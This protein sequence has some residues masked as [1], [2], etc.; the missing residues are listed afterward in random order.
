MTDDAIAKSS[1]ATAVAGGGAVLIMLA[2]AQFLMALDTSVMNVCIAQVA[3][4]VHTTVTGIQSAI[5]L[6][7]L[8]MASLMITGGKLGALIG[9]KRIFLIG[10]IVY[11][12]GSMTTA[13]S[14]SLP[15]LLI[16]WSLLEGIGAA[17]IMPA[18][19]ALVAGN[20]PAERRPA[21]YGLIAAA[22]AMAVAVGPLVG[23]AAATYATWRLVFAGEVLIVVLIMILARRAQDAPPDRRPKLDPVGVLLS[24]VGLAS[25]V[26]GVLKSSSWG[27][28]QP[29]PDQPALFGIS[30]VFWLMA[31]GGMVLYCFALWERRVEKRG[32]EPLVTPGIL[33]NARL[34]SGLNSFF[35][36]YMIQAGTFFIIP[37][38]L[39]V[40]L[41]LSPIATGVR[42]LPLSIGLLLTAVLV[43]RLLPHGSPRRIVRVGL[44][45]MLVSLLTLLAAMDVTA[46]AGVVLV[47]LFLMGLGVGALASQLGAVTVSAVPDS[48]SAEVGGLQNTFMFLGSSLGTALVGAVLIG[49]L[50]TSAITGISG[51]TGVPESVKQEATVKMQ[52]GVPFVSDAQLTAAMNEAGVP[53]ATADQVLAVNEQARVEGLQSALALLSALTILA[54][55]ATS[56][57]PKLLTAPPGEGDEARAQ[58]PA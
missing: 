32:G 35:F 3:N 44:L 21:A 26:Y 1:G 16:G 23:G 24:I 18:I 14:P 58:G 48:Q 8:V 5:T 4:D 40:S 37:L 33:R 9:R 34:R 11:G 7:T 45:M 19:V 53:K 6:Y 15:V 43:P 46:S 55:F 12:C 57:L 22:G 50:T 47:P 52:A 25:I 38:F 31:G 2:T 54:L 17:M 29:K 28:V 41:G 27:W 49:A 20:F 42:L 36:Q 13:L 30:L 39:S 51:V 10:C 56:R